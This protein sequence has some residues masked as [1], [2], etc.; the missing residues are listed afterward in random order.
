MPKSRK[1][2]YRLSRAYACMIVYGQILMARLEVG[3]G[4]EFNEEPYPLS[5]GI[6][7]DE[8]LPWDAEMN[9]M[10]VGQM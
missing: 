3:A 6:L 9:S 8:Y 4:N 7:E 2:S 1:K 5:R 10:F